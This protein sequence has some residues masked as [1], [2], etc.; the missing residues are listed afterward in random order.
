MSDIS[1]GRLVMVI[2]ALEDVL[3]NILD[4]TKVSCWDTLTTHLVKSL[5][6]P[7]GKGVDAIISITLIS[8]AHILYVGYSICVCHVRLM[9]KVVIL[10]A[11]HLAE[12][13]YYRQHGGLAG[14][15]IAKEPKTLV[16]VKITLSLD[17]PVEDV[18]NDYLVVIS[19]IPVGFNLFCHLDKNLF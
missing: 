14:A 12:L 18:V 11:I 7:V 17:A 16:D 15:Y 10:P 6:L 13:L 8:T 4:S 1:V 2:S 9:F 19:C 5:T 3:H